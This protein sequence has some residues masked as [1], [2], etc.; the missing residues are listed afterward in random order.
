MDS[1]IFSKLIAQHCILLF[2]EQSFVRA[3][4][5]VE[6]WVPVATTWQ[7]LASE[8]AAQPVHAAFCSAQSWW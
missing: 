8:A 2:P 3:G 4:N 7:P 1:A 5:V 6:Q